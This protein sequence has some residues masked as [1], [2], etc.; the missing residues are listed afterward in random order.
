MNFVVFRFTRLKLN[1]FPVNIL[2]SF[3]SPNALSVKLL[4]LIISTATFINSAIPLSGKSLLK[5]PH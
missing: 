3:S 1:I 4:A 2:P 5:Q